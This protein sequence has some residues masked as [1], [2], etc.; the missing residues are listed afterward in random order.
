M[1]KVNVKLFAILYRLDKLITKKLDEMKKDIIAG[2]ETTYSHYADIKVVDCTRASYSKEDQMKLDEYAAKNCIA[3][4][5][6]HYKRIDI[7]K[8][9]VEVD[10]IT[11]EIIT[12][13][14]NSNDKTVKRVA[15]KVADNK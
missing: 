1:K 12:T 8:I 13:L 15:S 7:D 5:V 11:D 3:K 9:V 4:Q 6:T 14:E 2:A 10:M